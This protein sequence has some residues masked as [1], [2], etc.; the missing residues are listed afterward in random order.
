LFD[1][2]VRKILKKE[3]AKG[4]IN[5]ILTGDR[6][7]RKLNKKYRKKDKPTDVLAF[8]MGEDGEIGDIAISRETTRRNAKRFGVTYNDELRRLVVHGVLHLLGYDHGR[9]MTDAE[10]IYQ[11]L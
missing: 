3:E 7:I 10:K 1:A 5:I 2:L 9:K 8:P 11:E 6:E 4:K